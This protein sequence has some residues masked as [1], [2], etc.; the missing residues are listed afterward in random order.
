MIRTWILLGL[1]AVSTVAV[2]NEKAP[3][4]ARAA[5][6]GYVFVWTPAPSGLQ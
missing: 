1:A 4:T 3:S 6:E 5:A 2:D